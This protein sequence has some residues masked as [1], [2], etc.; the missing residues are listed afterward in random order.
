VTDCRNCPNREDKELIAY[1]EIEGVL[2]G[3]QLTRQQTL[4]VILL[5]AGHSIPYIAYL[6]DLSEAATRDCLRRAAKKMKR[7]R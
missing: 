2:R 4:C 3:A 6:L 5:E 1:L 7:A